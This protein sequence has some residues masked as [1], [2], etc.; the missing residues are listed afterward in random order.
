[1]H[2]ITAEGSAAN[3]RAQQKIGDS[4]IVFDGTGDYLTVP[5]GS[6]FAFG[7]GDFTV[8]GWVRFN[9]TGEGDYYQGIFGNVTGTGGGY[10]GNWGARMD[11]D[12][13]NLIAWYYGANTSDKYDFTWEPS[14]NQW[15][16]VAFSREGTDLKCFIDGT[17]IG[18]TETD[19]TSYVS[20][21]D[22][23]VGSYVD[24]SDANGN[25]NGY[26]DEVR[27]SKGIARYTANF[28]TFGQDGGT[29]ANPTPFTADSNT[30][31]LIHSDWDG[32]LGADSSGNYN[33]FTATNL[34]ATD[35]MEDSPTNN[36][37]TLNP[38]I[39]GGVGVY[40]EEGNL[41]NNPGAAGWG[42][43]FSTIGATSGKWYFEVYIHSL[44]NNG[45][46]GIRN[47]VALWDDTGMPPGYVELAPESGGYIYLDGLT[48]I[49]GVGSFAADDIIGI[50]VNM[51]DGEIQ[52]FINNAVLSGSG[53]VPVTMPTTTQNGFVS[54]D[55]CY[56]DEHTWNFGQDSSFAGTVTAQGN[57]DGNSIGDF[58]YEPPSGFLALCTSNLSAPEIADPTDHFNTKLYTGDG[59]TTLAVTGVGFAPDLTWIKNRDEADNHILV[60]EVRGATKY[61]VPNDQDAEVDDNTF[62]AS[63]D[64][65]GFTV[66]D[67]VV[68]NTN[69]ENY[70]SWNWKGGGTGVSNTDGTI[71][72]TVSANTSA[73]FSIVKWTSTGS[74]ATVGHGLSEAPTF[75]IPKDYDDGGSD[76]N[77]G[78][79]L[80]GWTEYMT[81]NDA[82]QPSTSSTVWQ[83]TAPT[84]SVISVGTDWT[85]TNDIIFYCFHEVEGYSKFTKYVAN[86]D[87]DGPFIY[88]GF[89]PA[90]TIIKAYI[91][92]SDDW[93]IQDRT[94]EPYNPVQEY[95]F[96]NGNSAEV[97]SSAKQIDYVSNGIK[98]RCDDNGW[99]NNSATYLV[100]AFA[101][102]P[103]KTANAR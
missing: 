30:V 101:E 66:G 96:S 10:A 32:G 79:T 74:N 41:R 52:F 28:T 44:P 25:L 93:N 4:S 61:L 40:L 5:A 29:I 64:S 70:V 36:F 80:I 48:D 57:Q 102:T 38:L 15:Y 78:S 59:A 31:L 82:S 27:I 71:T 69:T 22:T 99:N 17:Q 8:E 100:M 68:V 98:I 85:D 18:S 91:V 60:D 46:V 7:T 86:N 37:A 9:N 58:Y 55:A 95:L 83:D 77:T 19:S 51:D 39:G 53:N 11:P 26:M 81:L 103:F 1:V 2:T 33:T 72:S 84:A 12:S 23:C 88:T 3:T 89:K 67:D 34:A 90:F 63:L 43:T 73:G 62:V 94:R 75:I 50:A 16:H 6:D 97:D 13:T 35:Q 24:A 47:D 87:D 42:R 56:G 20:T 21:V 76:W 49:S 14:E 65:D 92:G 54:Y 45:P